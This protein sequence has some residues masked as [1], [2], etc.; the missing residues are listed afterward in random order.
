MTLDL[1]NTKAPL[2]PILG[3]LVRDKPRLQFIHGF[4]NCLDA[5]LRFLAVPA[6]LELGA[7]LCGGVTKNIRNHE[8]LALLSRTL[9]T[10]SAPSP[11]HRS[12]R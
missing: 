10:G 11:G 7:N 2:S 9:K 8:R 12:E 1:G 3:W 4:Q 5:P 6:D